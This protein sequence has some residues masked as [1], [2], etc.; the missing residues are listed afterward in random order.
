MW[1]GGRESRILI[2][3]YVWTVGTGGRDGRIPI[4][5]CFDR[6]YCGGRDIGMLKIQNSS[7]S[8]T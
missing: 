6:G 4:R 2:R 7:E 1:E 8:V 5:V 3:T